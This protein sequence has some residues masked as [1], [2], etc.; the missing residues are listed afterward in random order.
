MLISTKGRYAI[1]VLCNM[2]KN[3]G[4]NEY[5]SLP[6]IAQEEEI[7]LKYLE[8]IMLL[9]VKGK[10][11]TSSHGKGGGYKLVKNIADYSILEVLEL[12]EDTLAPVECLKKDINDCPRK[13]N[14]LTVS[15]WKE[16]YELLTNYFGNKTLADLVKQNAFN[17]KN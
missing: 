13:N 6:S 3:N 17:L 15:M 8:R 5:V 14:C 2:A 16:T 9:L 1:R 7:S 11:V 4:L 10:L 12:T